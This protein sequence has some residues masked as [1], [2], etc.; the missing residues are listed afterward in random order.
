MT[1]SVKRRTLTETCLTKRFSLLS[2][3]PPRAIYLWSRTA[4]KA[5]ATL[6]IIEGPSCLSHFHCLM[7]R[8][9]MSLTCCKV[10]VER[11]RF[12]RVAQCR[13]EASPTAHMSRWVTGSARSARSVSHSSK[14]YLMITK[15]AATSSSKY[16][17]K[18]NSCKTF[19]PSRYLNWSRLRPMNAG[20]SYCRAWAT[21]PL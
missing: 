10:S 21:M 1:T 16:A 15:A 17:T 8:L 18:I 3:A 20:N 19:F 5:L 14:L 6:I 2:R 11:P 4:C 12:L 7:D 9:K 13:M